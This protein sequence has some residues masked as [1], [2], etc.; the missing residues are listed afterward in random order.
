MSSRRSSGTQRDRVA[1]SKGL[2]FSRELSPA[3]QKRLK[4]VHAG[5]SKHLEE[6]SK[7]LRESFGLGEDFAVVSIEPTARKLGS[8]QLHIRLGLVRGGE[9]EMLCYCD[10][11]GVC[12]PCD[13]HKGGIT[14]IDLFPPED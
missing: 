14:C 7:I 1:K 10:P 9:S 12:V 13:I 3:H 8:T 5:V 6:A 4:Q 11:P 2:I